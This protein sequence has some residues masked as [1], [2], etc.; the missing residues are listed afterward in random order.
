MFVRRSIDRTQ[1]VRKSLHRDVAEAAVNTFLH[2][3]ASLVASESRSESESNDAAHSRPSRS[4]SRTPSAGIE[5]TTPETESTVEAAPVEQLSMSATVYS[6]VAKVLGFEFG[7][8]KAT[9]KSP[10]IP[11]PSPSPSAAAKAGTLLL[12][13]VVE[14]KVLHRA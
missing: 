2:F 10:K 3:E 9:A 7:S 12:V 13:W 5:N 14:R 4:P 6:S 11:A 1:A 8:P